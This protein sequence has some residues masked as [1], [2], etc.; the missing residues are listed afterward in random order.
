MAEK[1]HGPMLDD[2]RAQLK[3][4]RA[5]T[6]EQFDELAEPIRAEMRSRIEEHLQ[7]DEYLR[8]FR[9]TVNAN[10]FWYKSEGIVLAA[11]DFSGERPRVEL[12]LTPDV[13]LVVNYSGLE[14]RGTAENV[15]VFAKEH[16]LRL[17]WSRVAESQR[18]LE[19]M[20]K[21]RKEWGRRK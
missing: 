9:W 18:A 10:A 6:D 15:L 17:R 13:H 5:Q 20:V 8:S 19:R 11:G 4:L 12:D 14:L 2:L 21:A 3:E 16:K 1:E 7:S